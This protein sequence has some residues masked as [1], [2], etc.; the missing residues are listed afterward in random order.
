MIYE[1][2]LLLAAFA[3]MLFGALAA[4]PALQ[5]LVGK[6]RYRKIWTV[7]AIGIAFSFLSTIPFVFELGVALT[8]WAGT[9]LL[10]SENRTRLGLFLLLALSF[11]PINFVLGGVGDINNL[12]YLDHLRILSLVLLLPAASQLLFRRRD[13]RG[14]PFRTVDILLIAYYALV[15]IML[16]PTVSNTGL[17]RLIFERFVDIFVPYYVATRSLRSIADVRFV[18][19]Y[20]LIG[21]VF[22]SAVGLA[23]TA[24]QHYLYSP[25]Q[26]I[27]NV[28]WQLTHTLLRGGLLR[29]QATTQEPIVLGFVLTIGIGLWTWL[30]DKA[31]LRPRNLAIFLML[32]LALVSTWSRG[33]WLGAAVMAVS[34]LV[35]KL[36]MPRAYA[37]GLLACFAGILVL[38]ITGADAAV[39]DAFKQALGGSEEDFGTIDYRRRLLDASLGLIA[40]SPWL[41]VANYGAYLQEFR[42]GEGIIDLV[43]SYLIITLNTGLVGLTLYLLPQAI[44][45]FGMLRRLVASDGDAGD[46]FI[47]AFLSILLANGLMLF[48]TSSI[49]V[50]P[51]VSLFVVTLSLVYLRV[52]RS[53]AVEVDLD[54]ERN[55]GGDARSTALSFPR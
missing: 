25:L 23:E 13:T 21:C 51:A 36:K 20:L 39:Y 24:T 4:R 12:L 1:I 19:T 45:F 40:Q 11:P 44:A 2:K 47:R 29:V 38:K 50:M 34:I 22:V 10:G 42:Q 27:Y 31:W 32:G 7:V 55:V 8:A 5:E 46:P 9:V 26:Y 18:A 16:A 17:V 3:A 15:V 41:G 53:T 54:S 30:C 48:T 52:P 37:T 43:N 14:N 28:K 49:N 6:D 35:L 33:P